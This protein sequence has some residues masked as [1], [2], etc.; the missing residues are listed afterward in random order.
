MK[1]E[2]LRLDCFVIN[3]CRPLFLRSI[4]LFFEIEEVLFCLEHLDMTQVCM[5]NLITCKQN[6][7]DIATHFSSRQVVD[8]LSEPAEVTVQ[9]CKIVLLLIS[10]LS[11]DVRTALITHDQV[12]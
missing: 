7:V 5:F 11:W 1:L 2:C 6:L 8:L 4:L 12:V 9:L 10:Q 3:C